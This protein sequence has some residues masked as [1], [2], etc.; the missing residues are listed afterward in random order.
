MHRSALVRETCSVYKLLHST[1]WKL[2]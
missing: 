1:T 2:E